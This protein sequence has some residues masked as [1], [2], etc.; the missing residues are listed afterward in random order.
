LV[1]VAGTTAVDDSGSVVSPGDIG[2][3]ARFVLQKIERALAECRATLAHVVRTRL[4]VTSFDGFDR[5]AEAHRA[6][7]EGIDPVATC[8]C[9]SALV[10]PELLIEIEVDAVV[11]GADQS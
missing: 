2:A 11:V 3:Q 5:V 10:R 6:F 4:F 7:F 1:F 9:V 8:V